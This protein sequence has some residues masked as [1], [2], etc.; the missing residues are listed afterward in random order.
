MRL[1]FECSELFASKDDGALIGRTR[2]M[3]EA[4]FRAMDDGIMASFIDQYISE[5][6]AWISN[7]LSVNENAVG[8]AAMLRHYNRVYRKVWG[9]G[10]Y[11]IHF[12]AGHFSRTGRDA[13][14]LSVTV[15]L[16]Q[17]TDVMVIRRS[18]NCAYGKDGLVRLFKVTPAEPE[19]LPFRPPSMVRPCSHNNWDSVRVK[20]KWCLL[21]CRNCGSQWRLA[22]GSFTRCHMFTSKSG[23]HTNE[24]CALLH[25]HHRKQTLS[26]RRSLIDSSRLLPSCESPTHL[27][28]YSAPGV[29]KQVTH[30]RRR[31]SAPPT[32]WRTP[33][34]I[35]RSRSVC[36]V[37]N[38][39]ET[40]T[41][42]TPR[43]YTE[44]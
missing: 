7:G 29:S 3:F 15:F 36:G 5:S 12:H 20:R 41:V 43:C 35:Q 11:P 30:I 6:A 2:N 27:M 13:V 23:C 24:D 34:I 42:T 17:P 33:R 39:M 38:T 37:R 19:G 26:E 14:S 32:A 22:T 4:M 25:I 9:G 21:R 31:A 8:K 28:E 10:E 40:T 44:S 18:F 1:S 16:I